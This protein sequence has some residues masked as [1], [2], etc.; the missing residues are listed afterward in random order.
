MLF[1]HNHTATHDRLAYED[2]EHEKD[3]GICCGFASRAGPGACPT[4]IS[5][6][7]AVSPLVIAA[8]QFQAMP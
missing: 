7:L 8:D 6:D 1:V 5:T 3:G 2:W 4:I